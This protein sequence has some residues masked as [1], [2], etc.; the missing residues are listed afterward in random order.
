MNKKKV[1]VL[2]VGSTLALCN[3]AYAGDYDLTFTPRVGIGMQKY[4]MEWTG[5]RNNGTKFGNLVEIDEYIP[6]FTLGGTA[7]MGR[8]Y[9]DA[10]LQQTGTSD[11][12]ASTFDRPDQA[13]CT[14]N[15]ALCW[16][17]ARFRNS[18]KADRMDTA[19]TF[20][21]GF[22]NGLSLFGGYKYGKTDI[23]GRYLTSLINPNI[24]GNNLDGTELVLPGVDNE[25]AEFTADGPFL[26][27]GYGLSLGDGTLSLNGAVAFLDGETKSTVNHINSNGTPGS[28]SSTKSKPSATGLSLG[29]A[30]KAPITKQLNYGIHLDMYQYDFDKEPQHD[31]AGVET[32]PLK[33]KEESIGMKVSLSYS[34]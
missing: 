10:F 12:T 16:D 14:D 24:N 20:G 9:V 32:L 15:N 18:Y 19:I 31:A 6:T 25:K 28:V 26:G 13:G 2:S 7:T 22:A 1:L 23:S 33:V 34:F 5:Y 30:W 4:K 27:L 11:E 17:G 3:G 29:L 21:Y 8:F